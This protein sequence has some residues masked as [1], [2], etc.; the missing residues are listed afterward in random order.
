MHQSKLYINL[1]LIKTNRY[2]NGHLS[3]NLSHVA[4]EVLTP[5]LFLKNYDIGSGSPL[6]AQILFF[7]L[8]LYLCVATNMSATL[9]SSKQTFFGFDLL[10]QKQKRPN[11]LR[12]ELYVVLHYSCSNQTFDVNGA[13]GSFFFSNL[14]THHD[15]MGKEVQIVYR[16]FLVNCYLLHV[17]RLPSQ[18]AG[19]GG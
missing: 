19:A 18:P 2:K 11:C 15:L 4:K 14:G 16:L 3:I 12:G 7:F 5:V 17:P 10:I 9:H 6:F 1:V 8:N 13:W